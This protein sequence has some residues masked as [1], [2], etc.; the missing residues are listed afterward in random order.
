MMIFEC[1]SRFL[2]TLHKSTFA[3]KQSSIYSSPK[4]V[5]E[6]KGNKTYD[7]RL[8][9]RLHHAK[10][11]LNRSEYQGRKY[12]K[13]QDQRYKNGDSYRGKQLKFHV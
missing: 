10:G 3:N 8:G 9:L 11:S 1:R 4:K 12:T 2:C 7:K 6:E 13:Y 5:V